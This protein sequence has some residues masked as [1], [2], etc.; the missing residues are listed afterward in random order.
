MSPVHAG[1]LA[2]ALGAV[3]LTLIS[4]CS[5]VAPRI[6]QAIACLVALFDLA[7]YVAM[8]A[9]AA[10]WLQTPRTAGRGLIAIVF[11]VIRL[12]SLGATSLAAQLPPEM[13]RQLRESGI[14]PR[15]LVVALLALTVICVPLLTIGLSAIG[16]LL[17]A[18]INP[19]QA[20]TP[21]ASAGPSV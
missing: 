11:T 3:I 20:P 17:Y 9:L 16:G 5:L 12:L 4:L 8:G 10:H 18:V 21:A 15:S 2:G 19:G 6:S 1:L 7:L 13:L 14:A